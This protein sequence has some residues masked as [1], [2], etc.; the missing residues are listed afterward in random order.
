MA[1]S[2]K[3]FP[4]KDLIFSIIPT[5]VSYEGYL[6]KIPV[7]YNLYVAI[8]TG[9]AISIFLG[10]LFYLDNIKTYKKS[11][12]EILATGYFMNFTGRLAQLLNG[13][14]D[15]EFLFPGNSVI[16]LN[17][18]NVT[19]EVGVP[20]SHDSLIKYS[21]EVKR[22]CDIV[23][24]REATLSEP[25]WVRAKYDKGLLTICEYP[26]TLF[27]LSRYLEKEFSDKDST[28]KNSKKIYAYFDKK[29]EELKIRN[30]RDI[31]F[32]RIR[33]MQV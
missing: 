27:A 21:D 29:I 8:G 24:I 9:L 10:V 2:F 30:S 26:R 32:G 23:Y 14:A 3:F 1:F 25:Y 19:V 28:E 31:P 13:K 22:S 33:F 20:I 7:F 16:K 5:A 18:E 15:I 11:L 4:V 12:A 6:N 17:P